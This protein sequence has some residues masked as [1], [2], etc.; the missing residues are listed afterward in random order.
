MADFGQPGFLRELYLG[1]L[2]FSSGLDAQSDQTVQDA[3]N[4]ASIFR[5]GAQ[6]FASLLD[7]PTKSDES[8]R[9]VMSG[10]E[11]QAQQLLNCLVR[12]AG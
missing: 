7:K 8:R 6:A 11:T 1:L 3:D 2:D 10:I 4:L 5:A 9:Q 12:G